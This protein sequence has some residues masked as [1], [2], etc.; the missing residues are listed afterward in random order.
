[1]EL[2]ISVGQVRDLQPIPGSSPSPN[3]SCDPNPSPDP[4]MA[5]CVPAV[6]GGRDLHLPATCLLSKYGLWHPQPGSRHG[7]GHG[8]RIRIPVIIDM[9]LCYAKYCR[10]QEQGAGTGSRDREQGRLRG[11]HR[12]GLGLGTGLGSELGWDSGVSCGWDSG[13]SCLRIVG[14][15][16]L[17]QHLPHI[18]G[19]SLQRQPLTRDH[20]QVSGTP[21]QP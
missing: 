17:F 2:T 13:V 19:V 11:R 3:P 21:T 15:T 12:E 20:S 9:R 6:K 1:M 10:E 18:K 14:T 16:Q 8:I 4:S 5:R 7:H